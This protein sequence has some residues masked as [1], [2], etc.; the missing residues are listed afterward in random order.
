MTSGCRGAPY[1]R[2]FDPELV[3]KAAISLEKVGGGYR[4]TTLH[5]D[6]CCALRGEL[7]GSDG[8][9]VGPTTEAIGQQQDVDVSS[10]CEPTG[11]EVVNTDGD[12]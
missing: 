2:R 11:A 7:S 1:F 6:I 4:I 3:L 8:E 10:R 12:T 5:Q 9:H